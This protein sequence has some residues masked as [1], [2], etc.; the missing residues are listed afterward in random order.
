M[1]VYLEIT[2]I[3]NRKCSF[4][5]GTA[6][7]KL[8]ADP[9]V[10]RS[11]MEKSRVCA[12]TFYLHVLGEPLLHPQFGEIVHHCEDVGIPVNLTTNG[13]LLTESVQE[14]LLKTLIFRQINFSLQALETEE[15]PILDTILQF[16]QKAL[17]RRKDLYVNLRMWNASNTD[18]SLPEKD[19]IFLDR[20]FRTLDLTFTHQDLAFRK[21]KRSLLL[22]GRLYLHCNDFFEWPVQRKSVYENG[23]QKIYCHAL[24]KQVAILADGS[25]VPCCL[26]SEGVMTLGNLDEHTSLQEI[27]DSPR[28][29]RIREGFRNGT[30]EEALCRK[31]SYCS[32]HVTAIRRGIVPGSGGSEGKS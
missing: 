18:F 21:R 26:D 8:F 5:P 28:A 13:I 10:L 20:I 27:T 23:D 25:V 32:T 12:E 1:H 4:C 11:R 6:R 31:C 24:S 7:K 17:V 22:Q 14:L 19:R 30:A 15:L 3:C 16:C 29:Q 2:N 9:E